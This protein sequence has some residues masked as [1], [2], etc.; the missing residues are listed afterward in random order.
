MPCLAICACLAAGR[1]LLV[2]ALI[3]R[4]GPRARACLQSRKGLDSC[5]FTESAQSVSRHGVI[6][7]R[8]VV[9]D[10]STKSPSQ[11]PLQTGQVEPSQSVYCPGCTHV[12][13][14][15]VCRCRHVLERGNCCSVKAVL[16]VSYRQLVSSAWSSKTQHSWSSQAASKTAPADQSRLQICNLMNAAQHSRQSVIWL[17]SCVLLTTASLQHQR[18]ILRVSSAVLPTY[19]LQV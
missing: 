19:L 1:C 13:C 2:A 6:Y 3:S 16:C 7:S 8:A 17:F 12:A 11:Q 9:H 15:S 14:H 18:K 10:K 5:L 4:A